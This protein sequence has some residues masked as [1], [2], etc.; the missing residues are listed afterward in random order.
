LAKKGIYNKLV[1]KQITA[2]G[3]VRNN[4]DHGKFDQFI[5]E[6]VSAMLKFCQRFLAE[7]LA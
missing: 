6:D 3:D 7:F 2:F 5:N 4:A 1:Q